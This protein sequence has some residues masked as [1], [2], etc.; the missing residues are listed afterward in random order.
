M[1]QFRFHPRRLSAGL[2]YTCSYSKRFVIK[3]FAPKTKKRAAL[4]WYWL[5]NESNG[6]NISRC[7][8]TN[9]PQRERGHVNTGRMRSMRGKSGRTG[10]IEI[11]VTKKK[12][13]N[14]TWQVKVERL[15]ASLHRHG[16][17]QTEDFR[18]KTLS[19]Y[20]RYTVFPHSCRS[21]NK[22]GRRCLSGA[23][24][25]LAWGFVVYSSPL[26]SNREENTG[27]LVFAVILGVREITVEWSGMLGRKR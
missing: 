21:N 3:A 25:H 19:I 24:L 18:W 22:Y 27:W 16:R 14:E 2:R 10:E 5:D 15:N 7:G 9:L 23:A 4:I 11:W 8:Q 13:R 20:V 1:K 26:S 6:V 12:D 17:G